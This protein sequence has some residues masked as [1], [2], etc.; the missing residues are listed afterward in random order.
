[1]QD[2]VDVTGLNRSSIYNT[3]G[4]KFHLFEESLKHYQKAQNDVLSKTVSEAKS[5]KDAIISLFQGISDD[6]KRGNNKGCMLTGC[7]TELSAEQLDVKN[8]L[9]D[10]KD[11]AVAI[12]KALI[13]GAQELGEISNHKS[14]QTLALFLFSSLQGLRVTSM[15]ESN[16]EDVTE[17]IL[18]V[19]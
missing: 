14:P 5:P 18:S 7:T 1:M 17:E 4:D 19:L 3:F 8:F 6:I 2:L 13:E 11:R 16:L 9:I 12:F 10:N 15:I